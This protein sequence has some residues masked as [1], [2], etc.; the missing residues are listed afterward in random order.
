M[1][2]YSRGTIW[3]IKKHGG[4]L[5][6]AGRPAAGKNETAVIRVDAVLVSVISEIKAKYRKTKSLDDLINVTTN[7]DGKLL[8]ANEKLRIRCDKLS[9]A[10]IE[11]NGEINLLKSQIAELER[12]S[13]LDGAIL[14]DFIAKRNGKQI[15]E[16]WKSFLVI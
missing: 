16:V 15:V 6:G 11:K 1:Q 3:Q 13:A 9:A 7:Q 2:H 5:S 8:A 10:N 4:K 12:V 14:D